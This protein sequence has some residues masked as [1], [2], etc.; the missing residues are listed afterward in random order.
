MF[1]KVSVSVA[2]LVL[3]CNA[4]FA[5]IPTCPPNFKLQYQDFTI[6][7][8]NLV[9]LVGA[10]GQASSTNEILILNNQT[11]C[12]LCSSATQGATVAFLQAG[13]V[14]GVC[15]GA[16]DVMQEAIVGGEQVQ[17]IGDGCNSKMEMQGL[18][19][20]LGQQVTK[21]DGTGNA[22]GSHTLATVMDQA[23]AN[24]AGTMAESSVVLAG[25]LSTVSGGP[26][27]TGQATSTLNVGT[28][29]TQLDL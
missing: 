26:C 19:L 20:A 11:D 24:S 1:S 28:T 6:G 15:G 14:I 2:V 16:W 10:D 22:T 5:V 13:S 25:Q 27:T 17:L 12:K 4:A 7:S 3:L 21:L 8:I 23:A 29:Q 9:G 18:S